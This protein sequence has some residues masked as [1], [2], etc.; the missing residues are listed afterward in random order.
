MQFFAVFNLFL[1]FSKDYLRKDK[2]NIDI[3]KRS[4]TY[5]NRDIQQIRRKIYN[6]Y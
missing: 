2:Y 1:M 4:G 5:G 6:N 3:K